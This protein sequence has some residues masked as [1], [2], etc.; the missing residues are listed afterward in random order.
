MENIKEDF[1][2]QWS[3]CKRSDEVDPHK[4][5]FQMQKECCHRYYDGET[6]RCQNEEI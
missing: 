1:V 3:T 5:W 2:C 4:M 6:Y